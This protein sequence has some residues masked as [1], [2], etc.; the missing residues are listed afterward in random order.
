MYEYAVTTLGIAGYGRYEI[1]NFALSGFECRH[2]MN[3]W[4]RGEYL[5]LGPGAWSFVYGT[6]SRTIADTAE[7]TRRL[8]SGESAA[9]ET[10][11]PGPEEASRETILLNLRTTNGMDL[12]RYR[13]DFG[14]HVWAQLEGA[15]APLIA[16]GILRIKD[17]RARLTDRGVMLSNEA[18]SRLFP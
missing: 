2:N 12:C 4:Q 15:M 3:Y 11:T 14:P 10:E 9:I 5:G 16:E 13:R 18:L 8:I 1:S 6:R 7:Y 17:G